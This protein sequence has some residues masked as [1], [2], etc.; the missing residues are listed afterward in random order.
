MSQRSA[1]S[2]AAR[3]TAEVS[4]PPRPSVVTRPSG[5]RPW[6][7]GTIGTSPAAMLSAMPAVL[8]SRMRALAWAPSVRIGICHVMQGRDLVHPLHQLVGG[9]RHGRNH[10]RDLI[11]AE[12]LGFHLARGML[13]AVGVAD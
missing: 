4:E 7:P 2:A 11:A 12:N 6:K 1:P 13:D 3:A 9:A 8:T 10:D 5:D